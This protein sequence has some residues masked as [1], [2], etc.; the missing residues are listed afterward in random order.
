MS[1]KPNVVLL[2]IGVVIALKTQGAEVNSLVLEN[3]YLKAEIV[4]K[5]GKVAALYNRMNKTL[6]RQPRRMTRF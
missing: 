6:K 3:D 1:I 5:A 2:I 4:A